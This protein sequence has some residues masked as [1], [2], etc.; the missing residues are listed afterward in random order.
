MKGEKHCGWARVYGV[1]ASHRTQ[2]LSHFKCLQARPLGVGLEL[3]VD[4]RFRITESDHR[5][6]YVI[7]VFMSSQNNSE[8]ASLPKVLTKGLC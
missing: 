8:D 4:S 5:Y 7:F 1:R 2:E 6:I 3:E